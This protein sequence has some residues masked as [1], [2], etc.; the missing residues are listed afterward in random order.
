MS[1]GLLMGLGVVLL[2][3]LFQGS[4]MLPTKWMG[5]WA[6]ENYWLLFAVTAYLICPWTLALATI[7]RLFE[8]YAASP[9]SAIASAFLFGVGWG[10]GAVTFGL[11]VEALGLALKISTSICAILAAAT[12]EVI[13]AATT[14]PVLASA[15]R[16]AANVITPPTAS[17][18]L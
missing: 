17:P 9:G 14:Y 4:S 15:R 11:G 8:I 12:F 2:A 18:A 10:V 13:R 1:D 3:G 16:M 5:G 7:P 6:W